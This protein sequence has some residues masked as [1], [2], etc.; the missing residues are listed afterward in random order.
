MCVWVCF[1]CCC[2][3][4]E[5]INKKSQSQ[6]RINCVGTGAVALHRE[7]LEFFCNVSFLSTH[8]LCYYIQIENQNPQ[9]KNIFKFVWMHYAYIDIYEHIL[10]LIWIW[11]LNDL[12]DTDMMMRQESQ[13][14]NIKMAT[15][16]FVCPIILFF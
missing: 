3:S 5:K 11:L 4:V 16:Y 2:H 13:L 10:Y 9:E 1:R 15:F 7:F 8:R 12:N 6:K 14:K